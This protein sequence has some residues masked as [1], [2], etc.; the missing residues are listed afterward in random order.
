MVKGKYTRFKKIPGFTLAANL[1]L[2]HVLQ[3][4]KTYFFLN[5]KYSSNL[6]EIGFEQS[7]LVSDGG[8]AN[9]KIEI[10]ESSNKGFIAKATAI[11]DFDADGTYN[12]WQTDQTEDI[13]EITPD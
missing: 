3:M 1:Q 7:K 9:Y 2:N 6:V 11:T 8:K 10:T 5:S 12:V 4:E 13:K